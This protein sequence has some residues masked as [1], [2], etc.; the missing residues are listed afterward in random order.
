MYAYVAAKDNFLRK[1]QHAN[2]IGH[3]KNGDIIYYGKCCMAAGAV[4]AKCIFQPIP[5]FGLTYMSDP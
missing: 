2:D 1:I 5:L 3:P 4:S